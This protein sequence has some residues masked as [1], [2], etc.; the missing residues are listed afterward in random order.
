MEKTIQQLQDELKKGEECYNKRYN[1]AR[2]E[3]IA[4][5]AT[6]GKAFDPESDFLLCAITDR[7]NKI[8][9]QIAEMSEG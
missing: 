6:S 5:Y 9:A 1:E 3:W 4:W 8:K 7:M 2:F